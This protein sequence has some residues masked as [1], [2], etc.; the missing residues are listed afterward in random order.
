MTFPIDMPDHPKVRPLS[1]ASKWFFVEMNAYS[2]RLGLDGRIPVKVA[3]MMW[4]KKALDE[5]VGSDPNRPL[6]LL[7]GDEYVIR[8]YADHQLTADAIERLRDERSKAGRK[9]AARRWQNDGKPIASAIANGWQ[10]DGTRIA[11][12][13]SESESEKKTDMTN[14]IQV[15]QERY[16]A[17]VPTDPEIASLAKFAGI[18]NLEQLQTAMTRCCGPISAR[19]AIELAQTICSRAKNVVEKV[20]GYVLTAIQNTPDEVRYHYE[21]LDLGAIA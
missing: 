5:L 4:P 21:R 2:R 10:D 9:G 19:G 20:D 12:S 15:S 14:E 1:P 6:V 8:D 3:R 16:V 13:E 17:G 11:E 18:K 7:D